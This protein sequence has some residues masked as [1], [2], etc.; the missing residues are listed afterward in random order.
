M[1]TLVGDIVL[2]FF[3]GPRRI[4]TEKSGHHKKLIVH[5]TLLSSP[6]RRLAVS[7]L[8]LGW[9]EPLSYSEG[10]CGH[11]ATLVQRPSQFSSMFPGISNYD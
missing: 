7:C 11:S 3:A 2:I 4:V 6:H 5:S 10:V 8:A 1:Q 9:V